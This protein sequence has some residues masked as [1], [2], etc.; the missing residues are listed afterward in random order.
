[1]GSD[2][3]E[4]TDS[5][6][7][8]KITIVCF[9][10]LFVLVGAID[11]EEFPGKVTITKTTQQLE[12]EYNGSNQADFTVDSSGNLTVAPSGDHIIAPAGSAKLQPSGDF[13]VVSGGDI[14]LQSAN[15][16]QLKPSGDTD[17]Y[18]EFYTTSNIPIIKIIGDLYR[19]QDLYCPICLILDQKYNLHPVCVPYNCRRRLNCR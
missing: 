19:L 13:N 7:K 2:R 11:D 18:L 14:D 17:D 12:L 8:W 10:L 3:K 16:I 5:M 4:D 15:A 6:N 1:M 9:L